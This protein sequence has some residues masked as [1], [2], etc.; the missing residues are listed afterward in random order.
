[1]RIIFIILIVL[2]GKAEAQT[3]AL[4]ISDSLYALGNYEEAILELK[5]FEPKTEAVFVRLAKANE[6]SGDWDTALEYY[7]KILV[8]N[9]NRVLT[10]INYGELLQKVGDIKAADSLFTNL[11]IAYPKNASFQY[12][13]GEIKESKGDSIS[14][15]FFRKAI[16]LDTTHQQALFKVAKYELAHSNYPLAKK[17]AKM[18][19]EKNPKNVSLLSILAQTYYNQ[20]YYRAAMEQFE[21]IVALGKGNEFVYNKLGMCYYRSFQ[22]E[23]AIENFKECLKFED[24]NSETHY[25][26]GKLYAIIGDF[27]KSEIELLM[28][29]L[30]KKQPVDAEFLS[31]ALAYK[32]LEDYKNMFKYTEAALEENPD[33]ERALYEKAIAADNYFKDIT[34]KIQYYQNYVNSYSQNGNPSLIELAQSRI[35]DLKKEQHLQVENQ[36]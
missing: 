28:A 7:H 14:I 21:K 17:F 4:A 2:V 5:S 11:S 13:L 35:S 18:G 20:Q 32:G 15:E 31:L 36:N 34:S 26:L 10:A 6:A 16:A 27:Q 8:Q 33:N 29:I 12:R 23:E 1:M 9:P 19:L 30:I 24:R 3:S 22:Y 25:N